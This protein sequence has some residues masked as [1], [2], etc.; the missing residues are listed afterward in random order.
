MNLV[1]PVLG[2]SDVLIHS[3][4]DATVIYDGHNSRQVGGSKKVRE[5]VYL[6]DDLEMVSSR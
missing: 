4:P 1:I 6:A 3:S 2:T 5:S